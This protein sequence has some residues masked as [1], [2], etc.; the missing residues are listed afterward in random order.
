MARTPESGSS[1]EGIGK[2]SAGVPRMHADRS[3][4]DNAA[5]SL[6]CMKNPVL[7]MVRHVP[8]RLQYCDADDSEPGWMIGRFTAVAS[9]KTS[10]R[11]GSHDGGRKFR[12]ISGDG[13]RIAVGNTAACHVAMKIRAGMRAVRNRRFVRAM[14]VIGHLRM[15]KMH[16]PGQGGPI[17]HR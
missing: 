7:K 9:N 15:L 4:G 10:L 5:R 12:R 1:G 11:V 16:A 8:G 6:N 3:S 2:I 14:H 17:A 13:R